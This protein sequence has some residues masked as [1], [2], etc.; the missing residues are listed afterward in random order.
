MD[1]GGGLEFGDDVD[2]VVGEG[3]VEEVGAEFEELLFFFFVG[4]EAVLFGW[5]EV[6]HE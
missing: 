4:E 5:G 1:F 3:V 6:N 2:L